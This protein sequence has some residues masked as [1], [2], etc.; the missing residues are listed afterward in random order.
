MAEPNF[1]NRTLYHGDNLDFLRGMNSETVHLIATDPPFNKSRD[2]HATPDSLAS[3]ASFQ[4]RWSWRDDVHEDW[5]DQIQGEYPEVWN[6]ITAS[7]QSYGYDMAAFLCFMG[8][9]LLEMRRVLRDDGSIY[10]HCD[11]TASHY[12]KAL[13]DAIFGSHNFQNEIT[14]QRTESH[15]TAKRYG[16]I[17]D[18]ILFYSKS[19]VSTWNGGV[20]NYPSSES[21]FS[22]Q[23]LKRYRHTDSDR[24]YYRLDDLTAPRPDSDSGKFEWRGTMPSSSRGWG[25]RLEQLEQWWAEG[26][27]QTKRDG[28]PRMDGLKVYLDES[29][30]KPLRNIWTDIPRIPNTSSE[31]TGYPTQKPLALYQRMIEASSNPGDIV[32]DP[33]CGCATTPIAAER[34]GRQWVGMDIWDEAHPVVLKRLA[35]EGLAVPDK[36]ASVNSPLITFGDVHYS[37]KPPS[38]TDSGELAVLHLQTI[39]GRRRERHPAPRTQHGRLITDIGPFCQGCGRDYG[40]DPRVLEVDHI[41]PKSDGGNDA[42]DNLTLLCPPCNKEKRDWYTLT[43]LQQLNRENGHLLAGNERNIRHGGASRPARRTRRR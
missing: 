43:R 21:N 38:R 31:R 34:L 26:R 36:D 12:L 35:D 17:A 30:G 7:I 20:H 18:I 29:V 24:R 16:N 6:V 11:P 9:R 19:E 28:T 5:L 42:Y 25:Y 27:I 8:V 15:N 3:G 1:V 32:L 41:R 4:D 10:L 33:F 40:F 13:M 22:E 37:T 39:T 23:Q 2:F 14:W